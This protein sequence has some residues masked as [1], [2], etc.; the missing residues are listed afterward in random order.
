MYLI[1]GFAHIPTARCLFIFSASTIP[2]KIQRIFVILPRL[3]DDVEGCSFLFSVGV[4]TLRTSE[5][6]LKN[7]VLAADICLLK[8]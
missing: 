7:V 5:K 6:N 2:R 3:G 4:A 1:Y 8:K